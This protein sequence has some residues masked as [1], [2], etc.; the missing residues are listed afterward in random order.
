MTNFFR[1]IIFGLL[2]WI[3]S[4]QISCAANPVIHLTSGEFPPWLSP[5]LKYHGIASRIITDAFA[6]VGYD[7]E[8]HYFPWGRSYYLAQIGEFDGTAGW[9]KNAK[10]ERDFYFS[11]PLVQSKIVFFHLKSLPFVWKNFSDLK[12]Y[13]IS[14]TAGYA[15]GADFDL[16]RKSIPLQVYDSN[17]DYL[18]LKKI[19]SGRYQLSIM[20]YDVGL[21]LLRSQFSKEDSNQVTADA[22]IVGQENLYLLLNK[23]NSKNAEPK[24]AELIQKFNTGLKALKAEGRINEYLLESR[25]GEYH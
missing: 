20:D 17:N 25:R 16:A 24:N 10:R 22:K 21:F 3:A 2:F 8:F 6:K 1:G 9:Q 18:N 19:V 12:T 7:V 14:T 23:K 4:T 13:S 5:Q 11:D 15:Y